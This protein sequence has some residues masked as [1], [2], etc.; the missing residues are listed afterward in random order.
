MVGW[1]SDHAARSRSPIGPAPPFAITSFR[2]TSPFGRF[3]R[4]SLAP[5]VV[6]L[7][8]EP[9]ALGTNTGSLEAT[10]LHLASVFSAFKHGARPYLYGSMG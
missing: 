4:R 1:T 10:S 8:A 3:R 5:L 6:P 7:I 9:S 2:P